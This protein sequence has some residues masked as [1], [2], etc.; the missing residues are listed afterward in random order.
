MADERRK[1]VDP[2][3]MLTD[4]HGS[5]H[6]AHGSTHPGHVEPAKAADAAL[7]TVQL[8]RNGRDG[9]RRKMDEN[10]IRQ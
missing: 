1:S 4:M 5:K 3:S 6:G 8:V 7:A 2:I 9:K 10:I